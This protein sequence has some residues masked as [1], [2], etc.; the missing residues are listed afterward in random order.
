MDPTETDG[1]ELTHLAPL[2]EDDIPDSNQ[3]HFCFSCSE[4]INGIYCAACGNKNDNFRRSIWSLGAELFASLTAIENRLWRSLLSLLFN[5]GH[6]ARQF[7]NG[8]RQKWTSPVRMYLAM[9]II[10]FGYVS[11]TNTQLVAFGTV[12]DGNSPIQAN[13]DGKK[14]MPKVFFLER[15]HVILSQVTDEAISVFEE[16]FQELT[17]D[18]SGLSLSELR[19]EKVQAQKRLDELELNLANL[20]NMPGSSGIDTAKEVVELR[21]Q[22]LDRLIDQ[23]ENPLTDLDTKADSD[24]DVI[25]EGADETVNAVDDPIMDY[26]IDAGPNNTLRISAGQGETI[27]LDSQGIQKLISFVLKNPEIINAPINQYLPRIMFLMM[28]LSMLI[29]ALFIRSRDNAMLYDHL[30]HAAYIH[31]FSFLIL[32]IFILLVQLTAIPGLLGIYILILLIYLPVSARRMYSRGWIKTIYTSYSV[33]M[34]YTFVMMIILFTL[35][36]TGIID[37][38]Q[39]ISAII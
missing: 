27:E 3:A 25:N 26:G 22:K 9:S 4:P 33:G 24:E 13:V 17:Q 32:F 1:L 38:A 12:L 10:L 29:T 16:H 37:A 34:I 8:A 35:I 20:K 28:P 15:R 23:K 19:N 2:S 30:V 31:G 7:A 11:L 36:V 21:I 5:P 6:M 39:E 14:L 18:D